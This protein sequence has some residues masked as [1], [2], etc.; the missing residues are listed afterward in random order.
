MPHD[1]FVEHLTTIMMGVI[2]GT[3][4]LLGIKLDPDQPIHDAV[5]HNSAA[6]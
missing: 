6:S 5:P 1:K 4:E 3:A 2:G